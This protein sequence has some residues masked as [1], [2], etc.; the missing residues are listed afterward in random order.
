M[1]VFM[2]KRSGNVTVNNI[3]LKVCTK[4]FKTKVNKVLT[5]IINFNK[6]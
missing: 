4:E 3:P 2:C 5:D 6:V 1:K